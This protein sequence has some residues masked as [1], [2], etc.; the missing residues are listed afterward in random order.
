MHDIKP[1]LNTIHATISQDDSE[2]RVETRVGTR[3][4]CWMSR[5]SITLLGKVVNLSPGGLYLHC[6]HR[7][8]PGST[9][10]LS[11]NLGG[12]TILSWGRVVWTST[13]ALAGGQVGMGVAFDRIIRGQD[14][15]TRF[16]SERSPVPSTNL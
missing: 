5:D 12:Q 10:E 16:I 7:L 11:L 2:R 1:R 14:S 6:T 15:L 9:V 8:T 3:C 13:R 4:Q